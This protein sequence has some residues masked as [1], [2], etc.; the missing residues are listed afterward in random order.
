MSCERSSP[1]A[2]LTCPATAAPPIA[3]ANELSVDSAALPSPGMA[4]APHASPG[5]PAS[6][7]AS[8]P[9]HSFARSRNGPSG[10]PVRTVS[11]DMPSPSASNA[12]VIGPSWSNGR[13]DLNCSS[14]A[15]VAG[16]CLSAASN[17]GRRS[18]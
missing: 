7:S 11:S 5:R 18:M 4:S 12:P 14:C 16:S 6:S 9:D 3:P 2:C 1:V 15:A 10:T 8:D 13:T 17:T